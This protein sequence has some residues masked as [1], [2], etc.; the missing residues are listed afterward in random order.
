MKSLAAIR[1]A[2][3]GEG[4][5]KLPPGTIEICDFCGE[6]LDADNCFGTDDMPLCRGHHVMV[7][8]LLNFM[9]TGQCMRLKSG[10]VHR[11]LSKFGGGMN[12]NL[13]MER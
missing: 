3:G 12:K 5:K 1:A 10:E 11:K 8:E 13:E 4:M 6:P 9:V 7:M 2:A